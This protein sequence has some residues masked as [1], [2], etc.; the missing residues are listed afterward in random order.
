MKTAVPGTRVARLTATGSSRA[1]VLIDGET[2]AALLDPA[3]TGSFAGLADRS[4]DATGKG[5]TTGISAGG[6]ARTIKAAIDANRTAE[7][8]ARPGHVF[9][10]RAC[11]GGVLERPGHTEAAVD[12][13]RL[14]RLFPAGVVCEILNDDG[15]MARVP[16]LIRFC[17]QHG[18]TMVTI[19]DLAR[20]RMSHESKSEA[21]VTALHEELFAA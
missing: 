9:P 13:A 8:F 11:G 12:L 2:I 5:M 17:N 6:R 19:A 10:L 21:T 7:D 1:D 18:L 20:H 4:I 14:A 3:H 16:D 15:T